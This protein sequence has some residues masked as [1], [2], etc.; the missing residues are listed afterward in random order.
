MSGR[1][2]A[3]VLRR[4]A[5]LS[6]RLTHWTRRGLLQVTLIVISVIFLLPLFWMVSSS[7]K[8]NS[9]IFVFPP[10]LVP[11]HPQWQNYAQA[12]SYIPFGTYFLNSAIVSAATVVGTLVAC[13]P[14]AYAFSI[15]RWPGRDLVFRLV[16]ATIMLPFPVVMVPQYL[17]FRNVGW[18]GSLLPLMVPPFLGAFITP[19]FASSLAIFLLRQ[20]MLGLPRDLIDAARIDGAGDWTLLRQVVVPLSRGSIVT[21]V[22]FAFLTSWTAF[23]APLIFLTKGSLFTLSLGLQQYQSLHFTAFNYLMAASFVFCLPVLVAFI[24]AQRYFVQGISLTG[25]KG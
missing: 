22:L 5:S 2:E 12:L 9:E 16:L 19:Y 3:T 1:G 4:R 8:G 15:L 11:L 6:V 24:L 14:A 13:V 10:D 17:I 7:L 18:L 25:T 21:V 20:F 23:V